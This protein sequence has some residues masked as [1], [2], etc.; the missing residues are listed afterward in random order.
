MFNNAV[1]DL[2]GL[3]TLVSSVTK[4]NTS[5]VAQMIQVELKRMVTENVNWIW[6]AT[7]PPLFPLLPHFGPNLTGRTKINLLVDFFLSLHKIPPLT[8]GGLVQTNC[9]I[10]VPP[11]RRR[12]LAT[13]NKQEIR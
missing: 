1:L 7:T 4:G 2:A 13:I 3:K 11:S 12:A 10:R 8:E 9:Q 5:G 6:R